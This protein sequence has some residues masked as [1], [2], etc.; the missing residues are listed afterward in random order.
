MI[1][2][3]L[4]FQSIKFCVVKGNKVYSFLNKISCTIFIG[5]ASIYECGEKLVNIEL[6]TTE[7]SKPIFLNQTF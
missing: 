2:L 3:F 6:E 1:F 4:Q 7:L 5:Q